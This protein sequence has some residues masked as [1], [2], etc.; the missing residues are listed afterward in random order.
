MCE[1]LGNGSEENSTLALLQLN[2][3][4][5]RNRQ[6]GSLQDLQSII[7]SGVIGRETRHGAQEE[8]PRTKTAASG[9]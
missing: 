6:L 8:A 5:Q 1:Y 9:V 2:G 4:V 3:E 7:L